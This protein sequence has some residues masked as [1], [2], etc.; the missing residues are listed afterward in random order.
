MQQ[1]FNS[2]WLGDSDVIQEG[3]TSPWIPKGWQWG[4]SISDHYPMW[5]ELNT[6]EPVEEAANFTKS[7]DVMQLAKP[8]AAVGNS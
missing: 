4:G 7:L 1:Y 2:C 8:L 5:I 3:L 6:S